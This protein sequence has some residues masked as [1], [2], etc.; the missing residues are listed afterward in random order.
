M[1]PSLKTN[2]LA[3][4]APQRGHWREFAVALVITLA[5]CQAAW[6]QT[7]TYWD[8]SDTGAGSSWGVSANWAGDVIPP[9]ASNSHVVIDNRNGTGTI[10]TLS[11]SAARTLGT[12]TFDNIN[13][14]LATTLNVDTNFSGTTDRVLT[15]HG[16]ITLQNADTSVVF[17]GNNGV[18]TIH[19]AADNVFATSSNSLL[20]INDEA[21]VTGAGK[22]TKTGTGTL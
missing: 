8:G 13:S 12:I 10:S 20:R 11:I 21:V 2:A 9:N 7:T 18:L 16:G 19:L 22:I 15:L 5:F 14:K 17:R 1:D 3:L 6:A 4:L